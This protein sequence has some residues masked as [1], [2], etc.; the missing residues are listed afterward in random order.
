MAGPVAP[1]CSWTTTPDEARYVHPPTVSPTPDIR[2]PKTILGAPFGTWYKRSVNLESDRISIRPWRDD[3]ADRLLDILGNWEVTKWLGDEDAQAVLTERSEALQRIEQYRERI[4]TDP[5]LGQWAIEVKETGVPAGTVLLL[6]L[7]NGDGEV[8]IGWHLHPDAHGHGYASEAAQLVL[9]QAF[10]AGLSEV[11]AVTDL[12]NEPSKR[13]CRRIGMT[14]L[15]IY[16]K[17]YEGEIDCFR[18][19]KEAWAARPATAG[20]T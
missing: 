9:A 3:E 2:F 8:E 19:T 5:P 14:Y 15:G 1:A 12:T 4:D 17:W 10:D 20:A 13:V 7:P 16:S 11:Y 18:I 6:K